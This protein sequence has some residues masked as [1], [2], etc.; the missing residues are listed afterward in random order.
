[1]GAA[2]AAVLICPKRPTLFNG[3]LRL[4]R[5]FLWSSSAKAQYR[6]GFFGKIP[7][8]VIQC[9]EKPNEMWP[10][11][12]EVQ[13][14]AEEAHH[15]TEEAPKRT[16]IIVKNAKRTTKCGWAS[17]AFLGLRRPRTTDHGRPT[18][19]LDICCRNPLLR[20]GSHLGH[21][22]SFYWGAHHGPVHFGC[23]HQNSLLRLF[24]A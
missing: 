16:I 12:V 3:P 11:V 17:S 9:C 8:K 24:I 15:F 23:V 1:M 20:R 21:P 13:V 19:R 22:W 6:M 10:H 2:H 18:S 7:I 14:N 5:G 4:L